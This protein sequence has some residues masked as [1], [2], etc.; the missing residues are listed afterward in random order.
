MTCFQK[1]LRNR[2]YVQ[3]GSRHRQKWEGRSEHYMDEFELLN[4]EYNITGPSRPYD[5]RFV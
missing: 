5:G 4:R 2:R 3:E 1:D